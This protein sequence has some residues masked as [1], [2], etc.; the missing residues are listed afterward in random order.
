MLKNHQ[1]PARGQLKRPMFSTS[2]IIL[3][4]SGSI[5]WVLRRTRF[6]TWKVLF[7]KKNRHLWSCKDSWMGYSIFTKWTTSIEISNL[8]TYNWHLRAVLKT[9]SSRSLTLA[10]LPSNVWVSTELTRRRSELC[11]TW[12]QNKFRARVTARRSTSMPQESHCTPCL[13]AIILFIS[14]AAS[15]QTAAILSNRR[16]WRSSLRN[17]TIHSM[18]LHLRRTWSASYVG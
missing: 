5:N 15:S 17:G 7:T 14:Q 12:H 18:S 11:S 2:S 13:L 8:K 16:W 9:E 4:N 10:S 3:I 6:K 1:T